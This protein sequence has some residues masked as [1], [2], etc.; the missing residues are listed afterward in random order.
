MHVP[1]ADS[2]ERRQIR[3]IVDAVDRSSKSQVILGHQA[4][5]HTMSLVDHLQRIVIRML[6]TYDA[7]IGRT[8]PVT[9]IPVNKHIL[10]ERL[11]CEA[12]NRDLLCLFIVKIDVDIEPAVTLLLNQHIC[13]HMVQFFP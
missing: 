2:L 3:C 10:N 11:K 12:N 5:V 6:F 1:H 9:L 7:N 4:F 13:T 8:K